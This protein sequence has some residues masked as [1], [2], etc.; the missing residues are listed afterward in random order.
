MLEKGDYYSHDE[1]KSET[2]EENS[3]KLWKNRGAQVTKLPLLAISQ[4]EC[5]GGSTIINYGMCFRVLEDTLK[6][7][8]SETGVEF[9]NDEL[10]KEYAKVENQIKLEK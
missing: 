2:R 4:G 5:V 1:I 10:N 8:K 7:W 6:I 3:Q 9:S